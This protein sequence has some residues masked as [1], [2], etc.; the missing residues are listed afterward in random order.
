MK[1][2]MVILFLIPFVLAAHVPSKNT[3]FS[4]KDYEGIYVLSTRTY[5][6]DGADGEEELTIFL[7][8]PETEN[9]KNT[10]V[11]TDLLEKRAD[12]GKA[13]I[14]FVR[15]TFFPGERCGP[16]G[17]QVVIEGYLNGKVVYHHSFIKKLGDF[18]FLCPNPND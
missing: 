14:F 8:R 5:I 7:V 1:A 4:I 6:S 9:V 18:S 15:I 2:I 3:E 12:L 17:F 10:L 11:Y 13:E 16:D